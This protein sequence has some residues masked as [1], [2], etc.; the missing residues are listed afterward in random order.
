M[1]QE[2]AKRKSERNSEG[3]LICKVGATTNTKNLGSA[4]AKELYEKPKVLLRAVGVQAVNQAVKAICIASN[5]TAQHGFLVLS[6]NAFETIKAD[7]SDKEIT[8][9]LF[10]CMRGTVNGMDSGK[11]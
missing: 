5:Y 9:I 6:F 4:V 8:S 7:D 3:Y 10:T 1:T 11:T 2:I